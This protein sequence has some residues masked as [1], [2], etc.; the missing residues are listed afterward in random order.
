MEQDKELY[1]A[2][3]ELRDRLKNEGKRIGGRMPRVCTDEACAEMARLRPAKLSD[4]EIVPGLGRS[5]E[6]KY[7]QQFLDVL[8]TYAEK[9]GTAAK[10]VS[11]NKS[12]EV[13][14]QELEKKLVNI[15]RSN[16]L[17]YMPRVSNPKEAFDLSVVAH[18]TDILKIIFDR[19]SRVTVAKPNM[20]NKE[21]KKADYYPKL[22]Q[23]Q[24]NINRII[25]EKGQNDLY[26]GYPFA[27]G[28]LPG[29]R[30]DVKAPLVL[31]PVEIIRDAYTL[32]IKFDDSRDIVYNNTLILGY[33][34]LNK[35]NKPL[36]DNILDEM[37]K[38]DFIDNIRE[39][40]RAVGLEILDDGKKDVE[41]F[42]SY[43]AD[44]FPKYEAGE[45]RMKKNV[46]IG[47][48]PT[49]SNSI[50]KDFIK[51][52]DGQMI[53][54][55]LD[56]LLLNMDAE[57]PDKNAMRVAEDEDI[58][59]RDLT[60][61]SDLNTAQEEIMSKI[62]T[63]DKLVIQGPP[64][65]G[66]SQTITNLIAD[67]AN[68]GKTVLMVSEKKAAL[69]VVYSRLG[70]LS[71][72]AMLIDDVNNKEL[73]FKQMDSIT[74]IE[75]PADV[76]PTSSVD[77]SRDIEKMFSDLDEL[78]KMIYTPCAF[79]IEPY[80]LYLSNK[81]LDPSDKDQLEKYSAYSDAFS[82]KLL[83]YDYEQLSAIHDRFR[84]P[85]TV[86]DMNDC[87]DMRAMHPWMMD[88]KPD[89]NE[90]DVQMAINDMMDLKK[91]IGSWRNSGFF[92]KMLNKNKM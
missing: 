5:F 16:R 40:Y 44:E 68:E 79:G 84:R 75:P 76:L 85:S 11:M 46:I 55:L 24:R 86:T 80:R 20:R 64:G 42:V 12:V 45:L 35:M 34:K 63:R 18:N 54:P 87:L 89:L 29:E 58:L 92:S 50:Q 32:D 72:Y 31:F 57:I 67:F 48:F 47:R 33:F 59:E 27:E 82:S 91:E 38:E 78:S 17:L 4:F 8:K 9:E 22:T 30:F 6:G 1:D 7:G 66:K 90:Y 19:G 81:K 2:L 37:K 83:D 49:Y 43:R 23:L 14:L 88:V 21:G 15:S 28:R 70:R 56:E 26:I 39:F 41:P 73:F 69:D 77:L 53:N 74:H 61:I 36:P 62:R 52:V 71:Q 10:T 13:A 51:I 25:R 3:I 65:T 60:Y